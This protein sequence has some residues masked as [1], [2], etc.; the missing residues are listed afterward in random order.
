MPHL[1]RPSPEDIGTAAT[2][3]QPTERFDIGVGKGF[4]G[5]PTSKD[6]Q[7]VNATEVRKDCGPRPSNTAGRVG[8]FD[9]IV[10]RFLDID[11]ERD[12]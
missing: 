5:K 2:V 9:D 8:P 6:G 12:S 1:I 4:L 3:E 10:G 11:P 7:T